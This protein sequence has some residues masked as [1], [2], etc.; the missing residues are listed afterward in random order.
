MIDAANE[1][2]EFGKAISALGALPLAKLI[3]LVAV[4]AED[5]PLVRPVDL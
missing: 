5:V 2:H 1:D 3:D 4:A